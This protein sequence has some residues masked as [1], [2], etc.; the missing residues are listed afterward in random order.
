MIMICDNCGEHFEEHFNFCTCC[1][2]RIT[3]NSIP[4]IAP[5]IR[6]NLNEEEAIRFYFERGFR[7]NSIMIFFI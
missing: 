5:S 2:E 4:G 1:S 7:Y 6:N 3:V